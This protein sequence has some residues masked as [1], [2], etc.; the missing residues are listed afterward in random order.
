MAS[1]VHPPIHRD[2]FNDVL[3]Y[4]LNAVRLEDALSARPKANRIRGHVELNL[5]QPEGIQPYFKLPLSD[6]QCDFVLRADEHIDTDIMGE[7]VIFTAQ[8]LR[9]MYRRSK[10][11][12]TL[13]PVFSGMTGWPTIYFPRNQE[14]ATLFRFRTH[15]EW[16][17]ETGGR[18]E[19][20]RYKDRK[21]GRYP[22]P[23]TQIKISA[24]DDA[25]SGLLPYSL[26]DR[27]LTRTLG[28]ADEE[29]AD[30]YEILRS[31]DDLTP[32]VMV[33]TVLDCIS[34][35]TEWTPR[36][37]DSEDVSH[38]NLIRHSVETIKTLLKNQ[39]KPPNVYG[40]GL[41]YDS[42]Q[43][44][45]T[46]HLQKDLSVAIDALRV[47]ELTPRLTPLEC[48]LNRRPHPT[49]WKA[50]MGQLDPHPLTTEQRRVAETFLGSTLMAAQGPPG[51]GKTRLIID[52]GA[53]ELVARIRDFAETGQMG[54]SVL[55]VS[56][57]NNR[58]V[59]NVCDVFQERE[60]PLALRSGSQN[61]TAT[62]TFTAL[63][64]LVDFLERLPST[65]KEE[66][67]ALLEAQ[68]DSFR[69]MN[70]ALLNMEK[71]RH[72][73]MAQ[74]DEKRRIERRIEELES[75]VDW[76]SQRK[77][78][79]RHAFK[80]NQRVLDRFIPALNILIRQLHRGDAQ[81]EA[82]QQWH[83]IRSRFGEHIQAMNT[84]RLTTLWT[85]CSALTFPVDDTE[86]DTELEWVEDVLDQACALREELVDALKMERMK[87]DLIDLRRTHAELSSDEKSVTAET[88]PDHELARRHHRLFVQAESV[89]RAWICCHRVP[90]TKAMKTAR[91]TANTRRSLRRLFQDNLSAGR[92]LRQVFPVMGCTLLSLGNVF[93][94]RVQ[95]FER[96]IID[97][98][99]QCHPAYAVA[100]LLRAECTLIIGDVH[101]LEPVVHLSSEDE[102][103]VRK[104]ARLTV[105][106]D[107]LAPYR[108]G[109][110][111]PNSAQNLADQ[112]LKNRPS[113]DTHFR[114]HEEII[115]V[116]DELCGYGLIVKTPDT[117][118]L[119]VP[120]LQQRVQFLDVSGQQERIRGSWYNQAEVQSTIQLLSTLSQHGVSWKD[121]AV[122]TPYVGQ[123]EMVRQGM[124]LARIPYQGAELDELSF[125]Q[126][127]VALGTVHR[128]QGGER[129]FVIFSTVVTQS[130]SL[131]FLN[132]RVNLVNV[133]ISR[134]REQLF[135]IGHRPVLIQGEYTQKLVEHG[136]R[137]NG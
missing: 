2:H 110:E 40:V 28:V 86:R 47:T 100:G 54:S 97:E 124:R 106:T 16:Y 81:I 11:W 94:A 101:Q 30:L 88:V 65:T 52:L 20:P 17:D 80:S 64:R 53:A 109:L 60:I 121:V 85:Q 6:R 41:I 61:V 76:S 87:L 7:K 22:A 25:V 92:W 9:R 120:N 105:T 69:Q 62:Q 10:R 56:S 79:D 91:D 48:Y 55:M 18:F 1:D 93:P 19:P 90:L 5:K 111:Q 134:A 13:E 115:S 66:D 57:T 82:R 127:G 37:I 23:P 83:K 137:P 98:G 29:L 89:R 49:G 44:Q 122:I 42:A 114:C 8:W 126:N 43:V 117:G 108:V 36:L 73:R 130:R 15:L 95:Q 4:W 58:A 119:P 33:A 70:A 71:L 128:F 116:S 24:V 78:F 99:G 104:A 50:M 103:R 107:V 133:A 38:E 77:D 51:T 75:V 125:D 136:C 45:T 14:L 74:S 84:E 12:S 31:A 68:L 96:L 131:A 118:P 113:L 32:A 26:D 132:D 39:P 27:L 102:S 67:Q 59:D 135:V 72:E 123:L 21:A 3:R 46:H 129:R 112:S 35:S 34:S 63:Q